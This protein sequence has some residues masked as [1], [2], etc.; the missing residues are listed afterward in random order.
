MSSPAA[1]AVALLTT[2]SHVEVL[3]HASAQARRVF[4]KHG[5]FDRAQKYAVACG[6]CNSDVV[7]MTDKTDIA[8]HHPYDGGSPDTC[9]VL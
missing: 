8:E 6:R 3:S 1:D 9:F 7:M 2:A 4:P 5:T